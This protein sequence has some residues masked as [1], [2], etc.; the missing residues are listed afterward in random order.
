MVTSV[1]MRLSHFR[2]LKHFILKTLTG[3]AHEAWLEEMEEEDNI[4][5]ESV[6][7][8]DIASGMITYSSNANADF[9]MDLLGVENIDQRMSDLELEHDPIIP[10]TGSLAADGTY[11]PENSDGKCV[12]DD[13]KEEEDHDLAVTTQE[14]LHNDD[15]GLDH[16]HELSIAGQ[17]IWSNR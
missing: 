8:H 7:L 4:H 6:T 11:N 5:E 17:R 9:L 1:K 2:R 13:I 16:V 15:I 14:G 3:G 12:L 10:F